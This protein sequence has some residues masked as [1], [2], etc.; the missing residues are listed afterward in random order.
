MSRSDSS[1]Q[2]ILP[3]SNPGSPRSEC[4]AFEMDAATKFPDW[5]VS[6]QHKE[7]GTKTEAHLQNGRECRPDYGLVSRS[8]QPRSPSSEKPVAIDSRFHKSCTGEGAM[9][10]SFFGTDVEDICIFMRGKQGT[11]LRGRGTDGSRQRKI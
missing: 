11:D 9:K 6:E 8:E 1:Q 4:L 10:N 2:D 7:N 5:S 3:W